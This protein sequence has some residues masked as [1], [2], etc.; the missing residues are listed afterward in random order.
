MSKVQLSS[1]FV[2]GL[3]LGTGSALVAAFVLVPAALLRGTDG[4]FSD[5][6]ALR[7]AV[8]RGLVEYWRGGGA[9]FPALLAKLV[10]YW[11]RWHAIK[12][13]ISV[14]MVMVFALLA[15]ALW[16]RYLHAAARYAV[17]AIGATVFTIL[18]TGL[19]ILNIQATAVPLV[20]L[21]PL[22]DGGASGGELAQTLREMREGLTESASPHA[23]SP[24]L[25]VLLGEVER[26]HWVMVAMA[27]T[28]MAV[29]GL[30]SASLRRRRVADDSRVRFM[31]RTLRVIMALTA[32]LL[33]LVAA[34]SAL[35]ATEPTSA[36]LAVI[37][38]S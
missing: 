20:A 14:L 11:F 13:V 18:A 22:L 32:S 23:S 35:S 6:P 31:R 10:D 27:A 15:V 37:D 17:G 28:A 3:L 38:V 24:A 30:A 29:T 16:R 34:A 8:G 4:A 5:E 25:T 2:I 7:G 1:R 36:L 19:L 12:V 26:Y 33:V 21:L 9:E